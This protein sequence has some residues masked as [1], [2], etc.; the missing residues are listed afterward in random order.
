MRNAIVLLIAFGVAA[1]AQ[2]TYT[3]DVARIM[4]RAIRETTAILEGRE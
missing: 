1:S 4:P 2:T 3:R